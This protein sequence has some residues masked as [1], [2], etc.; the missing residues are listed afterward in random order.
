MDGLEAGSSDAARSRSDAVER[1]GGGLERPPVGHNAN[2]RAPTFAEL[3]DEVAVG[4]LSAGPDGTSVAA[5]ARWH[6]HATQRELLALWTKSGAT[7]S[8]PRLAIVPLVCSTQLWRAY[9]PAAG[10]RRPHLLRRL[11][12]ALVHSDRQI[13]AG[14]LPRLVSR[15]MVVRAARATQRAIDDLQGESA[16]TAKALEELDD[17]AVELAS[18]ATRLARNARRSRDERRR[19]ASHPPALVRQLRVLASEVSATARARA[20]NAAEDA[21]DERLGRA[22]SDALRVAPSPRALDLV[23]R[24]GGDRC[25]R[26]EALFSLRASWLELAVG[27]WLIVQ[28]LDDLLAI[29]TFESEERLK[30]SIGS[31]AA[32]MLMG[33]ALR[34][35]PGEFDHRYAWERHRELLYELVRQVC[36][37]LAGREPDAVICSQQLALR[38]LAR[39]LAAIWSIDEHARRPIEQA[40]RQCR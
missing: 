40:S 28:A 15:A 2:G 7:S 18:L 35:R 4:E 1:V 10:D 34:E 3:W 36:Q 20:T 21:H 37:A 6:I 14:E 19:L 11:E 32:N 24:G 27:L 8:A 13:R 16:D 31:R 30:G 9:G 25:L 33:S 26:A 23:C 39:V 17:A 22:L 38:R 29:A 5:A 12:E